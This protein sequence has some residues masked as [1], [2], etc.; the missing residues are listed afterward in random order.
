MTLDRPRTLFSGG[1]RRARVSS[2]CFKR[3][4]RMMA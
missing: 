2:Q 4:I 3:S 1:Q